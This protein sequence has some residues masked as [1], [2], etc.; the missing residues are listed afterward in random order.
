MSSRTRLKNDSPNHSNEALQRGGLNSCCRVQIAEG[1]PRITKAPP[2]QNGR[3]QKP[4]FMRW[5]TAR[6]ES[7]R[8]FLLQLRIISI[9][10]SRFRSRAIKQLVCSS[11]VWPS[12]A[13]LAV[14]RF[15]LP[16]RVQALQPS[17]RSTADPRAR[18]GCTNKLWLL[19]AQESETDCRSAGHYSGNGDMVSY[20]SPV[21]PGHPAPRKCPW[22]PN[23]PYWYVLPERPRD[24]LRCILGS[25]EAREVTNLFVLYA[26]R[27]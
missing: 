24:P 20:F 10:K 3:P 21:V 2:R 27:E 5:R 12:C 25:W 16:P 23:C 9:S 1:P 26:R 14:A 7:G 4:Q 17:R 13:S 8:S 18:Q 15:R 19:H 22:S 6:V 11:P